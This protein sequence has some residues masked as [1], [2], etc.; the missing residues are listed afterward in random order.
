MQTRKH[1]MAMQSW[2]SNNTINSY[3]EVKTVGEMKKTVGST[4]SSISFPYS[5]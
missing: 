1:D 3:L 2:V 4:R 5:S